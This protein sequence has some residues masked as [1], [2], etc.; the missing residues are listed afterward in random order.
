MDNNQ[1]L[2]GCSGGVEDTTG[3]AY[4][5]SITVER[6]ISGPESTLPPLPGPVAITP[7]SI[8][9]QGTYPFQQRTGEDTRQPFD[10]RQASACCQVLQKGCYY[11][12]LLP[13]SLYTPARFQY[14][15]TL[16]VQGTEGAVIVSGDL[17]KKDFCQSPTYCPSLS[18]IGEVNNIIPVFPRKNYAYYLR[19]TLFSMDPE[20]GEKIALEFESFR[21][22]H[23]H[24]SWSRG[25]PLTAEL[26][27]S[28]GSDGI[29]HWHGDIRSHSEVVIGQLLMVRVSPYL[30]QAVIEIDR[31]AASECPRDEEEQKWESVFEKAGWQV[32]VDVSDEDVEEPEDHSWSTAE[33]HEK[34]L[35]Y[36][37]SADL[38]KQWRYHMLAVRQLD[39]KGVF[40]L[41]YDNTIKG[42]NN[43]PREGAAVASH[44]EFPDDD[45]WGKCKG[46]RFGTSEDPYLRTAI[47]EIGH[48][49]M[50]Y[51]PDNSYENYIM[52]KTVH[53]AHNV[54]PTRQFPEN[55]E[56]SFS[57]RD[58]HLLC[59]L[60]DIAIR[61][62]GVSFGTST[63]TLLGSP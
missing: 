36:R 2:Q 46:K 56:W 11:I 10:Y 33:L 44:V 13:T 57:P 19:A 42:V 61:P 63:L 20:A 58:I 50:L 6:K 4:H 54:S 22:D 55:I 60:P 12:R 17:Y 21:F 29:H 9:G 30:R 48:A 45:Y 25:E 47:H 14:E 43:I 24:Q 38:D 41:M 1:C 40:G 62:G 15:G 51:H 7:G 31:V 3:P 18:D 59:H 53:I 27:F 8:P 28:V 34:M 16:R 39:D 49:M 5:D 26:K 35:K 32:T 52:Q 23:S 37:R